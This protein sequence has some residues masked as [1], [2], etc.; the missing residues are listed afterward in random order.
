M[1]SKDLLA[2]DFGQHF[3]E[4]VASWGVFLDL[5]VALG[6]PGR[7]WAARG[8]FWGALGAPFGVLLA[9]LELP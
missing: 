8:P 7:I 6:A 9:P 3:R 2:S 4:I 1:V 5:L